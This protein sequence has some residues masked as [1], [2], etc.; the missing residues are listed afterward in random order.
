V[1]RPPQELIRGWGK[2]P[3]CK[4]FGP[5]HVLGIGAICNLAKEGKKGSVVWAEGTVAKNAETGAELSSP[6]KD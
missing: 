4:A 1:G 2:P 5:D 6:R 3:I